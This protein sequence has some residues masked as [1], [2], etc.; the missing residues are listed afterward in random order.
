MVVIDQNMML[1]LKTI[2]SILKPQETILVA[3]SLTGQYAANIASSFHKMY[4]V[5]TL[6]CCLSKND[7][8]ELMK[9][10]KEAEVRLLTN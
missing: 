1:E 2:H 4:G 3:D 10:L 6:K 7:S 5:Y 8:N 9:E